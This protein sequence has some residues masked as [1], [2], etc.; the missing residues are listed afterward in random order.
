MK[1]KE[2]RRIIPCGLKAGLKNIQKILIALPCFSCVPDLPIT[3][4]WPR[5]KY[6]TQYWSIQAFLRHVSTWDQNKNQAVLRGD[7]H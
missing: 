6:L 2:I 5:A 3:V 1:Y 4:L 7:R